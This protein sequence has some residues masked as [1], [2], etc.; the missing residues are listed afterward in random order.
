MTEDEIESSDSSHH[1]TAGI[2]PA[3]STTRH[4]AVSLKLSMYSRAA[5]IDQLNDWK[6]IRDAHGLKFAFEQ[7]EF[8]DLFCGLQARGVIDEGS[9]WAIDEEEPY[10]A[11]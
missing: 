9:G 11:G 1:P 4:F 7:G 5:L 10:A 3:T 2:T 8:L 6:D